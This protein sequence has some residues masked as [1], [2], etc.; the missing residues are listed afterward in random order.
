MVGDFRMK[1]PNAA[2]LN[3]VKQL[4]DLGVKKK[5]I[6]E[7]YKLVTHRNLGNTDCPGDELYRIVSKWPHFERKM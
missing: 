6:A 3:S 1:K 7:N 2:A 4:I 5:W